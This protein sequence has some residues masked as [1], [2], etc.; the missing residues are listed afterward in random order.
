MTFEEECELLIQGNDEHDDVMRERAVKAW[1]SACKR[2][3][4]FEIQLKLE[5][6]RCLQLE[7][8]AKMQFDRAE[9]WLKKCRGNGGVVHDAEAC[10]KAADSFLAM[11]DTLQ[12]ER[13]EYRS[14]LNRVLG[15]VRM[16]TARVGI[17]T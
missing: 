13:D 9:V 14:A 15:Y 4:D 1:E 5:K 17:Q 8:E 7:R 6:E 16:Q 3:D 12:K 2:A 11:N 10:D